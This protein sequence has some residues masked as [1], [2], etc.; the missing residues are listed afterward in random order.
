MIDKIL[1]V[2]DEPD[3]LDVLNN[4]LRNAGFKV[5]TAESGEIALKRVNHI[6]PD[7][8][9]LDV[10]MP[11]MDGFETCRCLKKNEATK[12]IPIIFITA[13][14]EV[15]DK[16]EGLEIGAVDYITKPFQTAE[17]IARVNNHLTIHRLQ[18]E[19]SQQ[20]QELKQEIIKRQQVE[21]KL[22][23]FSRAVEQSANTIMI[24]DLNGTIEFV[25][26]AFTQKTGYSY[27]EAI[28]QNPRSILSSGKQDKVF[29]QELWAT[30]QSGN[31]WRGEMCNKRK[32]GELYWELATFSP[33]KNQFEQVTHFV[34]IKEDITQRK[35]AE[36]EV[37]RLNEKLKSENLRMSAELE[38]SRQLQQMLL[39]KN[40]ELEAI[41]GLDIAG[42][43]EPADEVGGDYYDVIQH[44]GRVLFGIGD[45]TGHGLES[46]ALAIIVQ[47]AIRT[48]LVN[49]ETDPIKFL[50]ACRRNNLS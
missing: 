34:A 20:N 5:L 25:N 24:T 48:L 12:D 10:M 28:G 4:C 17:I 7:L 1:I 40:E 43:M 27:T 39:P 26:P 38:V 41:D 14:T 3:N 9:L 19:L 22:R 50:A 37:A 6:K 16:V 35:H 15:I 33:I 23:K 21:E 46:G 18:K 45:V 42:F 36:Q 31:V 8:I 32:N 13:K 47:S 11:R 44:S 2:D 30:I 29:Y 49:N